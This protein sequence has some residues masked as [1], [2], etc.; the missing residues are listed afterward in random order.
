MEGNYMPF[1]ALVAEFTE[2]AFAPYRHALGEP[3]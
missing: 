1:I 2:E 3:L